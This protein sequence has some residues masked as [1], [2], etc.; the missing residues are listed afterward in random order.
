MVDEF[1]ASGKSAAK[2]ID[3]LT[4]YFTSLLRFAVSETVFSDY[5]DEEKEEFRLASGEMSRER[6]MFCIDTL[7]KT[8]SN[9]R[10]MTNDRVMLDIAVIKM[11]NP[12]YASDDDALILRISELEK[13]IASGVISVSSGSVQSQSP[14]A[15]IPTKPADKPKTA[16]KIEPTS[17]EIKAISDKWKDICKDTKNIKLLIA[18]E[19]SSVREDEGALVLLFDDTDKIMLDILAQDDT[20]AAY[21]NLY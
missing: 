12:L 3:S 8:A 2:F 16:I 4:D 11:C 18:L 21:P 17:D 1:I 13:K 9:I 6:M 15:S 20:K 5:T 14:V 10:Y 7:L 19:R